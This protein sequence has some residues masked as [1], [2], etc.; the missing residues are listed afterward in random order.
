M[1]QLQKHCF[2]LVIIVFFTTLNVSSHSVFGEIQENTTWF[3]EE[4]SVVPAMTATLEYQIQY[5]YVLGR[6]RPLITFYYNRQNS[7][8]LILQCEKDMYGQLH[9][10]D[11]A[12]PLN[13]PYREK[14]FCYKDNQ[15]WFCSGKTTNQE[16]THFQSAIIVKLCTL[17]I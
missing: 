10:E 7:P 2:I 8:N 16:H 3:H 17:E 15:T 11:L 4:L 14:F 9:N 13:K 1:D 5:P 6:A 12:V